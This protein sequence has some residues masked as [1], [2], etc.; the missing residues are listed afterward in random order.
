MRRSTSLN[1]RLTSGMIKL[2]A[3][4]VAKTGSLA[5]RA[6]R[7]RMSGKVHLIEAAP[8]ERHETRSD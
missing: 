5:P 1:Q 4:P 6:A 7:Q 3:L 8:K 2:S